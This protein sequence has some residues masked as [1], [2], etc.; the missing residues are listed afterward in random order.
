MRAILATSAAIF[1]A[2]SAPG[3]ASDHARCARTGAVDGRHADL[4]A[5]RGLD[6]TD[7]HFADQIIAIT[8]EDLVRFNEQNDVQ[9]AGRADGYRLW[10][11]QYALGPLA[12][13]R[14]GV[15]RA[16]PRARTRALGSGRR[17]SGEARLRLAI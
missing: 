14:D 8:L 17:R 9:I 15:V 4:A 10:E 5:E 1:I 6:E 12:D 13:D 7:R 11:A 2:S 3:M 16:R